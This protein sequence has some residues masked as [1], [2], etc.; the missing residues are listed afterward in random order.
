[1]IFSI[2]PTDSKKVFD[3]VLSN[4]EV[5]GENLL[6]TSLHI[7]EAIGIN[8]YLIKLK[9]IHNL[10]GFNFFADISPYTLKILN[11]NLETVKN[12]KGYGIKG[13]RIDFGFNTDEIL[14]I[15]KAGFKIAINAS[16]VDEFFISKLKNIE[17]IA[18]HNYY[19]RPE[20]GIT[21][22][23]FLVQNML[24]EKYNIPIYVFIPGEKFLRA[25]LGLGLP[26]LE[27]QRYLNNYI[28]YIEMYSMNPSMKIVLSEGTP[29]EIHMKWI[30]DFE[31]NSVLTVPISLVDKNIL[32]YLE[33]RVFDIRVERTEY[34]WRLEGTRNNGVELENVIHGTKRFKGSLQMDNEL[35]GRYMGEIHIMKKDLK[36]HP[37][38]IRIA[39]IP[40]SYIKLVDHM[41]ICKK[42]RFNQV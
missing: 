6:Y 3:E 2:Y 1:M 7:P 40:N 14:K 29:Y 21:K 12:L 30:K 11:L 16:I 4:V 28:N 31:V 20:T 18:W 9:K 5:Y 41:D 22:K 13:L 39:E 15:A 34:S 10:K 19:P 24:F 38:V 33:S 17:L 8:D 36:L 27:N 25:P 35:Y 37:G 23:F 42:L 32:A 26:T